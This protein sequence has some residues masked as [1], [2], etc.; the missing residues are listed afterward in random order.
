MLYPYRY[1]FL[2]G[3]I[4]L[5]VTVVA[6]SEFFLDKTRTQY[7][8]DLIR[9]A[10]ESAVFLYGDSQTASSDSV[11][12]A[13]ASLKVSLPTDSKIS[14][15]LENFYTICLENWRIAESLRKKYQE[16]DR[17]TMTPAA[18]THNQES[19]A[20]GDAEG[21]KINLHFT[22]NQ[23]DSIQEKSE[24]EKYSIF[25]SYDKNGQPQMIQFGIWSRESMGY[26]L[27]FHSS[28][29]PLGYTFIY[30]GALLGPRVFWHKNGCVQWAKFYKRPEPFY[31]DE[32][33]KTME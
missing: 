17:S 25:L 5:L 1:Y 18:K 2:V 14:L 4:L 31:G 22:H 9:Q 33:L 30:Q 28:G 3:F 6:I 11:D 10:H 24:K 23:L 32:P 26:A 16:M 12:S 21:K 7:I 20:F 13:T 15:C 19:Y 27:N 8:A 29:I